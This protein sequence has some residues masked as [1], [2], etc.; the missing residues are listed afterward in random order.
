M[1]SNLGLVGYLL[2]G[3]SVQD[4]QKPSLYLDTIFKKFSFS[5]FFG[6]PVP[7]FRRSIS[8]QASRF[9]TWFH[10]LVFSEKNVPIKVM[11]DKMMIILC[12]TLCLQK[13]GHCGP[14]KIHKTFKKS[15]QLF[16]AY[17]LLDLI[18]NSLEVKFDLM[19]FL[20]NLWNHIC[21]ILAQC[22]F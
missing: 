10:T 3:N 22:A 9:C 8:H 19:L 21:H 4:W 14:K 2:W 11:R 7:F 18:I 20:H 13:S 16:G 12:I 6:K 1:G 17:N 15:D 5:I